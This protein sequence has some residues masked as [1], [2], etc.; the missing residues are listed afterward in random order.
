MSQNALQHLVNEVLQRAQFRTYVSYGDD[1]TLLTEFRMD[2]AP[3]MGISVVGEFDDDDK[4]RYEYCYPYFESDR[5]STVQEVTI[6]PHIREEGFSGVCD[7]MKVGVTLI[8]QL[9][10]LVDYVKVLNKRDEDAREK[11]GQEDPE[12]NVFPNAGC[13]LAALADEGTVML[14]IQKT[15]QEVRQ[16]R[17]NSIR[18]SR[19]MKQAMDG[20]EIAMQNLTIDDMNTYA[21]ISDQ[22]LQKDVYSIVDNYF[23]PYGVECDLYNILGEIRE[24]KEVRNR[25]T[26]ESMYQLL[27]D[28]NDLVFA[29]GINKADLYGEPAPGRRFRGIVWMQGSVDFS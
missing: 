11:T 2:V 27:V 24:V 9:Q 29:V 15:D 19:L 4:F 18:R 22:I 21:A 12:G 17:Q 14:P 28:C 7:D 23:A 13:C 26:D 3:Q 1:V 5:V 20:D 6:E 25:I 16:T 8:F 10:N